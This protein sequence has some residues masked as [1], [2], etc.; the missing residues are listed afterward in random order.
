MKIP[1]VYPKI[2][3]TTNCPL[4]QCVVFNKI[5]GTCCWFSRIDGFWNSFG[6]RRDSFLFKEEQ[7][8]IDAH[9]ELEHLLADAAF[10]ENGCLTDLANRRGK[11][12]NNSVLFFEY[13]GQNS[14]AG[15]HKQ[16]DDKLLHLI[17]VQVDN[18]IL[19]PEEFLKDFGG[20]YH[21]PKIL[22]KGKYSG[23]LVEDIRSNKF[24]TKEGAVIKGVVDGQAYMCK[25][26]TTQYLDKLKTEFKDNWE[27]YS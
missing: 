14:F 13:A 15:S 17:D 26:K 24:N 25:V 22:Y 3:D 18:R 23:Q 12:Y 10:L 8:F 16:E 19:P 2:P 6:T 21:L 11:K 7:E 20:Y 4:K 1:L 9:P 5:D 27:R